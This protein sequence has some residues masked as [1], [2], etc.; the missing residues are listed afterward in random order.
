[1]SH[2]IREKRGMGHGV[3]IDINAT[4]Q[5]T[6]LRDEEWIPHL[7]IAFRQKE[8]RQGPPDPLV[9]YTCSD[10]VNCRSYVS[11][12]ITRLRLSGYI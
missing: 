5:L 9:G 4:A 11:I 7:F 8:F 6:V 2:Q 10:C 1:M 12:H 3:P